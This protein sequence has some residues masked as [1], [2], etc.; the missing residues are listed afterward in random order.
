MKKIW[1]FDVKRRLAAIQIDDETAELEK[2][3]IR[4]SGKIARENALIQL[5]E[6]RLKYLL[7]LLQRSKDLTP[8][9]KQ[10]VRKEVKTTT[11]KLANRYLT[12]NR[13]AGAVEAYSR[14]KLHRKGAKHLRTTGH[15]FY[16]AEL[17]RLANAHFYG[18]TQLAKTSPQHAADLFKEAK[19]PLKGARVLIKHRSPTSGHAF[20]AAELFKE[21]NAHDEGIREMEQIGRKDLV[22]ELKRHQQHAAAY[23]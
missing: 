15:P 9:A 16:A 4:R 18:G 23:R 5:T 21:A 1:L 3:G 14:A 19:K 17:Y 12:A 11:R 22:E 2:R 7:Y 13:P 6:I 20:Y 8:V 10:F